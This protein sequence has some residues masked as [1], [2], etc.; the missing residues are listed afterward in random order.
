[1]VVGSTGANPD[2]DGKVANGWGTVPRGET[3][4][5]PGEGPIPELPAVLLGR[6]IPVALTASDVVVG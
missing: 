5:V 2:I 6:V 4:D 3:D 1:V